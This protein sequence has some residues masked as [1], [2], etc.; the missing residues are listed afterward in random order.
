[1]SPNTLATFVRKF[2][3]KT[4][5]HSPLG[6]ISILNILDLTIGENILLFVCSEAVEFNLL[7][8][9]TSH[10]VILFPTASVI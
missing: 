4:R 8:L 10:P 5:E 3:N 1:M 7:N 2:V 6:S 9:E